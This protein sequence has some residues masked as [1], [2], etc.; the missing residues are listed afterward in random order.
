LGFKNNARFH[1]MI[2]HL[3]KTAALLCPTS[4]VIP[5]SQSRHTESTVVVLK[6]LK[7]KLDRALEQEYAR[8]EQAVS[9]KKTNVE[10]TNSV[11]RFTR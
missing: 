8:K 7:L 9:S 1:T 11:S 5:S 10:E 3:I 4:T 2:N 6:Q